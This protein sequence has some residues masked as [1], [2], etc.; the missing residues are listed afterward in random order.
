MSDAGMGGRGS[1]GVLTTIEGVVRIP[2]IGDF[3]DGK[4][5]AADAGIGI[6][7]VGFGGLARSVIVLEGVIV[8]DI[9]LR[10]E[11]GDEGLIG[12]GGCRRGFGGGDPDC[13]DFC[14][15][16]RIELADANR[17]CRGLVG[18][19]VGVVGIGDVTKANL[20]RFGTALAR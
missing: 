6:W 17:D 10:G 18:V 13:G 11:A 3:T 5:E 7:S 1:R 19:G 15:K 16:P 2:C 9:L 12:G 8:R 20:D 14:P 4:V